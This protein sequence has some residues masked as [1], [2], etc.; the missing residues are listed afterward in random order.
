MNNEC[1]LNKE[2]IQK[3]ILETYHQFSL[4]CDELGLKHWLAFGTLLGAVRHGDFIPWD[5]DF[6]VYMPRQDYEALFK[7]FVSRN[8][9]YGPYSLMDYRIIKNYPYCCGRFNDNRFIEI[10]PNTR[11]KYG[12][13]I[14]FDIY[15]LDGV[16]EKDNKYL[17]KIKLNRKILE[18]KVFKKQ[19]KSKKRIIGF[20]KAIASLFLRFSSPK[21][22]IRKM[23]KLA[24][25][26]SFGETNYCGDISWDPR[27][28]RMQTKWFEK[29]EKLLFHGI[30]CPVPCGYKE[31]LTLIYRDYMKLP[32]L[33]K[34]KGYHISC[35]TRKETF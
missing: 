26:Y 35:I 7:F 14:N 24:K 19:G 4:I 32:P 10:E 30:E 13:G 2:E 17:K 34:R 8:N 16:N 23:Q 33:E 28:N 15:P 20:L 3:T 18:L 31:L 11:Q 27:H 9:H 25:K 1:Y 6:D 12:L 29:T 22:N 21:R 5:D